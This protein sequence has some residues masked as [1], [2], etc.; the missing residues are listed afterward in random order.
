MARGQARREVSMSPSPSIT[1]IICTFN[2]HGLLRAALDSIAAFS[3][4]K[5]VPLSVIIV[6]NSDDS[7][8]I[9]LVEEIQ[10][11]FPWPLRGIAAHPADISVA[12]NAGVAEASSSDLV[13][14]IDD[15]QQLPAHWLEAVMD[16]VE[17]YPHDIFFG[18]VDSRFEA[19]EHVGRTVRALFSRHVDASTGEEVFAMGPKKTKN[20]SLGTGNSIF[21]RATTLTDPVPFDPA[22]GS[23]GGEDYNLFC[24]LQRRGRRFAWLDEAYAVESVPASRCDPDYVARRLFAG[25]Q[26]YALAVSLNS[27]APV[28]E[29]WR[30]R[31]IAV[32]QLGLMVPVW[33]RHIGKPQAE[34]NEVRFR[35]ASILGKLSFKTLKPIYR[36]EKRGA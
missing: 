28:L 2:R 4:P 11:R 13:A 22:F 27:P 17:K 36:E 7:N 31:L 20:V 25:G 33:L 35:T 32:V 30:Q 14:F 18:R 23:G 24:R 8:A 9:P 15:D 26:A 10:S 1:I 34:R 21:R 5:A 12:R 29:R 6:D 16:A 19:P 3:N